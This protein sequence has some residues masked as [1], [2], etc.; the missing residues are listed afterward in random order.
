MNTVLQSRPASRYPVQ[1]FV[2]VPPDD[3]PDDQDHRAAGVPHSGRDATTLGRLRFLQ[4]NNE[5]RQELKA[6]WTDIKPALPGIIRRFYEHLG[7]EPRLKQLI[8]HHQE[9][10]TEAQSVHWERLFSGRFDDDY[11]ASTRRIGLVHN[12]IGLEPAWY[13]GGYNFVLNELVLCLA[14]SHRFS[15]AAL[16][17]KIVTLNKAVTLDMSYAISV[18]QD[19]LLEERERR[20]KTLAEAVVQFSGAVNRSLAIAAEASQALSDSAETLDGVTSTA[21]ALA[22]DVAIAARQTA[23]NMGTGAAATEELAVSVREI[24]ERANRSAHVARDALSSAWETK[25]TIIELADHAKEIGVVVDLIR[26]VASQTNMLA[27]NATIEAARAGEAGRGFAVVAGEVKVLANQTNDATAEIGNRIAAIQAATQRS[28]EQIEQIARVVEEVSR[29]ATAIAASVEEQSAV[30][31]GIATNV[32][33]TTEH[34]EVVAG[35]I[36]TLNAETAKAAEAANQVGEAKRT[37]DKEL[38]NLRDVIST[39]LKVANP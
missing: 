26:T 14:R 7:T 28:V 31:E 32:A 17:R 13:I 10:L 18:Y 12:R 23:A 25:D 15:G 3:E 4:I 33:Q 16:A 1:T 21:N 34:T 6:L 38:A 20:G 29:I 9:R 37:L 27:L 22:N 11:V 2:P 24:G 5:T 19:A 36:A 35:N 8:G 39:F 30:T